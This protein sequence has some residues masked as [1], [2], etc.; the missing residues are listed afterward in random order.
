VAQLNAQ[1]VLNVVS[2][3]AGLIINDHIHP[4][5]LLAAHPISLSHTQLGLVS[6]LYSLLCIVSPGDGLEQ[7]MAL[8]SDT[9]TIEGTEVHS[10]MPSTTAAVAMLFGLTCAKPQVSKRTEIHF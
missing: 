4:H 8:I 3:I 5:D 7:P 1:V 6:T 2:A 9:E 10:N